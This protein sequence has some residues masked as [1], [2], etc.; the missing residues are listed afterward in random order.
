MKGG[1]RK[2]EKKKGRGRSCIRAAII[3]K[4]EVRLEMWVVSI[5]IVKVF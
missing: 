4:D 5:L 2:E 3:L 1:G